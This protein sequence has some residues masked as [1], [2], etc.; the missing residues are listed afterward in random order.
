[1]LTGAPL[2][3]QGYVIGILSLKYDCKDTTYPLVFTQVSEF[4]DDANFIIKYVNYFIPTTSTS[5]TSTPPTSLWGPDPL[6][7]KKK[8]NKSNSY[9]RVFLVHK[10]KKTTC[11]VC[12][13][14]LHC[15][16]KMLQLLIL[17][18]VAL[19]HAQWHYRQENDSGEK[20][21][22]SMVATPNEF[23]YQ[24]RSKLPSNLKQN[25]NLPPG[26]PWQW[27]RQEHIL[28]RS[29]PGQPDCSDIG[30]MCHKRRT[31]TWRL[32]SHCSRCPA[33]GVKP[34]RLTNSA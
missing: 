2:I 27:L 32:E 12:N 15:F 16:K 30:K 11:F 20:H 1:M 26:F 17:I 31:C 5:T 9:W 19:S 8:P 7:T 4:M 13:N 29:N 10:Y 25:T 34:G 6:T 28:Q 14:S 21:R 22:D 33:W 18:L 3:V 24:V 23:P